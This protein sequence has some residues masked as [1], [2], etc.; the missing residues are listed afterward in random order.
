MDVVALT[1][2]NPYSQA[3]F[4]EVGWFMRTTAEAQRIQPNSEVGFETA[5]LTAGSS[6]RRK[7]D[8]FVSLAKPRRSRGMLQSDL[9]ET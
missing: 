4:D 5:Q 1:A 3:Q 8:I 9:I 2:T 6:R 7:G